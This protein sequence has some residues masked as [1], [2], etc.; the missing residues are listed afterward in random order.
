MSAELQRSD[1]R[2]Q[3]ILAERRE[4]PR[5]L[6]IP[7][8]RETNR[9]EFL[10]GEEIGAELSFRADLFYSFA[11]AAIISLTAKS[12]PTKIDLEMM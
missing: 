1:R 2:K 4:R 3:V 9:N 7:R 8:S 11:I 10:K 12:S 5:A 6:K